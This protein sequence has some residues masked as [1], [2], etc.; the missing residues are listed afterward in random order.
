M[1]VFKAIFLLQKVLR[2]KLNDHSHLQLL[3]IQTKLQLA[4]NFHGF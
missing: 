2:Q 4:Q 3:N 1:Q